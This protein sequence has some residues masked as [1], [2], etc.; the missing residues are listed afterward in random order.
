MRVHIFARA[1]IPGRCKTRLVPR[2]GARGAAWVQRRLVERALSTACAAAGAENVTL[3]GAPDTAHGF[4]MQCRQ[5]FGVRLARQARGDL[6]VRMRS[7]LRQEPG[8]L[9]GSDA[10]GLQVADL[11][12]AAAALASSDYVLLP[13]PDGGYVLI[14]CRK[15]LPPLAG[16]RW[17][18]GAE[19]AQ[20]ARRL[21]PRGT[22]QRLAPARDDFDNAADWRRARRLGQLPPLVRC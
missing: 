20:T 19:C 6:G 7:A 13:A 14:G 11:Q 15:P 17:S 18:S 1:P 5:R 8:L 21:R 22:L 16:V 4:F 9:I 2:L 3:W 12:Q 10:F